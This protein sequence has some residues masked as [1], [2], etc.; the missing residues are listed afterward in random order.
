MTITI[1]CFRFEVRKST[2]TPLHSQVSLLEGRPDLVQTLQGAFLEVWEANLFGRKWIVTCWGN[3]KNCQGFDIHMSSFGFAPTC[4]R[5]CKL[6]SYGSLSWVKLQESIQQVS[7]KLGSTLT[8]TTPHLANGKQEGLA[9][10]Q[11]MLAT[12]H[13]SSC[14][15]C[16][17]PASA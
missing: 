3:Q 12:F 4:T 2:T 14:K 5:C 13:D 8:L 10:H 9:S 11:Q 17:D 6:I 16:F 1:R 15:M 7:P